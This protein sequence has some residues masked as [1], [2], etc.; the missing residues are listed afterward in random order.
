MAAWEI[1]RPCQSKRVQ[2]SGPDPTDYRLA[3]PAQVLPG[4]PSQ[5]HTEKPPF[6]DHLQGNNVTIFDK[7]IQVH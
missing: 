2:R 1:I 6:V 4:S 7:H 5:I 3:P